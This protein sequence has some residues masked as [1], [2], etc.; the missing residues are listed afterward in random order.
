MEEGLRLAL[1][2]IR[3]NRAEYGSE[4]DWANQVGALEGSLGIIVALREWQEAKRALELALED[5]GG[6][7]IV[8]A[9]DCVEL[10]EA[11]LLKFKL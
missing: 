9:L 5:G 7:E 10:I 3:D 6:K 1:R 4:E 8:V 2:Q 11:A